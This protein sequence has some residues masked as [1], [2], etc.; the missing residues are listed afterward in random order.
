MA[1]EVKSGKGF[2]QFLASENKIMGVVTWKAIPVD[3]QKEL[4]ASGKIRVKVT[5]FKGRGL[6]KEGTQV[7]KTMSLQA[8]K[9]WIGDDWYIQQLMKNGNTG[10]AMG[11]GL[12]FR[13]GL[14]MKEKQ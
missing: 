14:I 4:L 3:V 9:K 11:Q 13:A 5:Q 1:F 6:G 10:D 7:Q 12:S 2:N 8:F